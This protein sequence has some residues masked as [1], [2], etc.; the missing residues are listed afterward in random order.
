MTQLPTSLRFHFFVGSIAFLVVLFGLLSLNTNR[1]M[2]SM[3]K[4]NIRAMIAQ[5]SE[6]LNLAIVPYT[7]TE[8]LAT[9][10]DYLDGLITGSELGIVYLAL[11]DET[12]RIIVS[13]E[14]TP[15]PIPSIQN[16]LKQIENSTVHVSQRIL[17]G[18]NRVG[19]LRFG[20]STQLLQQASQDLYRENLLLIG[21]GLFVTVTFL[22]TIGGGVSNQLKRLVEASQALADGDHRNRAP[23]SGSNELSYLAHNFNLMADAV[24]ERNAALQNSESK[25]KATINNPSLLIGLLNEE[26]D[27]VLANDATMALDAANE[28]PLP[29][30]PFW[31]IEAFQHDD[32]LIEQLQEAVRAGATGKTSQF[33][34]SYINANQIHHAEFSIQ[35]VTDNQQKVTGLVAQGIDITRRKHIEDELARANA[36]WSQAMDQ[37]EDPVYLVSLQQR[38][39]RAN[40]AFYKIIQSDPEHSLGRPITD[41]IHPHGDESDCPIC[42]ARMSLTETVITL[43]TDSPHNRFGKPFEATIKQ[44]HDDQGQL[45]GMLTSLHDLSHARQIEESERLSV[46]VF[47]NTAEAIFITDTEGTVLEINRAFTEMMGFSPEETIGCNPRKWKSGRHDESYYRNMWQSL[48]TTGQWQGEIWNRRKDGSIFPAWGT[49][50]LV[51]DDQDNPTHYVTVFSDVS[52]IKQSEEQLNHLAHHDALT[53]LPNRLLFQERLEQ[54]IRHAER[55]HS[56]LAIVFL[57]L[58]DFKTVNDSLGHSAGDTLLQEVAARLTHAVRNDDTVARIGG[59]EFVVLMEDIQGEHVGT[60][61]EKLIASFS[62]PFYLHNREIAATSSMGI[63]LYPRDGETPSDLMRNA[64]A[65]L[66]RAKKEG[67]NTY[68]FYTE[69]MTRDAFERVLLEN[70]LRQA[71]D[72]DELMLVYQPQVNIKQQRIIGAEALIRWKH[73]KLG[74]VSPVKFIPLAEETGLIHPIGRWVLLTACIQART[75]LDLG[76]EFGRLSVNVAG[77]QI[78]RGDLVRDVILALAETDLPAE[79]LELEV[80]EGFIMQDPELAIAQLNELRNLGVYLSIDDFGTGYSSLS[81]LKQLPIHKLKIDQSFMRGIPDD[82]NDVAIC[83][84]IIAMSKSLGLQVISEGVET[85]DQV[86]FLTSAGCQE[87]QGYLFSKP[88][89]PNDLEAVLQGKK[90]LF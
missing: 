30:R 3:V 56:Q 34:L 88:I 49:I 68:E 81:Y 6:T 83:H 51:K 41:L 20:L 73:P 29:G 12:G 2:D 74:M 36:E 38:L 16:L 65:A 72:K 46:S 60:V 15:D 33:V 24:A 84:A 23:E 63:A 5:T 64:D 4:E 71:I 80:T 45:T 26:G 35:P 48:I 66:Y 77:P 22:I 11:L 70:S 44:V 62:D 13:T 75:W 40:K 27:V 43:E 57:D 54:A 25:L 47:D 53:D 37:F 32:A 9:L 78:Q 14:T 50:S 85:Q 39:V 7:T 58:D 82:A 21:I 42:A 17:L 18:N 31:T 1:V 8:E 10:D 86:Q 87:A 61:A 69:Q 59:D 19:Q 67:R 55:Q 52:Q 76:I 28:S 89:S 79:Y 90:S